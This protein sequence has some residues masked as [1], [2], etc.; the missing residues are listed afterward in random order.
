VDSTFVWYTDGLVERRRRSLRAALD[1][2]AAAAVGASRE[3][4]DSLCRALLHRMS[5]GDP[6]QDDT[7]VLCV[8]FA[9]ASPR[10]ASNNGGTRVPAVAERASEV[11]MERPFELATV[12]QVR[13]ELGAFLHGLGLPVERADLLVLAVNE[14]MINALVHGGGGGLLTARH[15]DG[16][17]TVAVEDSQPS[18]PPT[19]PRSAPEPTAEAGRGLWLI[20]QSF[21]VVRFEAGKAGLRL[22]MGLRLAAGRRDTPAVR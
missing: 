15:A 13:H 22:V 10:A 21:D 7:V 12:R 20:V 9:A 3:S 18:Q 17:L 19:L 8:Q 11:V 16:Q 5:E 1:R 4:P 2:L 14:G 6:L